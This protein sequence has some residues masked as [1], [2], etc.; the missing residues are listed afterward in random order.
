MHISAYRGLIGGNGK[1]S[2]LSREDLTDIYSGPS[3]ERKVVG[4]GGVG[5]CRSVSASVF[6]QVCYCS[7]HTF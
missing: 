5:L 3:P 6:F 1:R 4:A 2:F 7:M